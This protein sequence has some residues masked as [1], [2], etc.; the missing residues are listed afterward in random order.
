MRRYFFSSS[1]FRL[2]RLKQVEACA[3]LHRRKLDERLRVISNLF[4]HENNAPELIG[5]PVFVDY[6]AGQSG[7]LKRVRTKWK[8]LTIKK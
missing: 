7:T 4:A 8:S 6:R 3:S 2:L 5:E 1:A